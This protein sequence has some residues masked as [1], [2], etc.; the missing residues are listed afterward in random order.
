ME[1]KDPP[2]LE[3][4]HIITSDCTKYQKKTQNKCTVLMYILKT[5]NAGK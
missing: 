5:S 3:T 1:G 4:L 2:V